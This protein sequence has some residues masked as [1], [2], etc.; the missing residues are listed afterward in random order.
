MNK[1][2]VSQGAHTPITQVKNVLLTGP[3]EN[4]L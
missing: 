4:R 2:F 3:Q 1:E